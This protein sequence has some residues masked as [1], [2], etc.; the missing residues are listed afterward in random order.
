MAQSQHKMVGYVP[1]Y[2]TYIL[3]TA[4]GKNNRA[5]LTM[6]EKILNE[7]PFNS[8]TVDRKTGDTQTDPRKI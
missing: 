1:L 2:G 6:T 4:N 7:R 3:V 8:F 5:T